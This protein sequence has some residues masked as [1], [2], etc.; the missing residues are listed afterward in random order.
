MAAAACPAAAGAESLVHAL[1][2]AHLQEDSQLVQLVGVYGIHAWPQVAACLGGR[3]S[4]S[5][6]LR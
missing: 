6:S 5:C 4:K 3:D 1:T 2:H